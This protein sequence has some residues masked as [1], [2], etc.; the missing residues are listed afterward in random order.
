LLTEEQ[1]QELLDDE[2]DHAEHGRVKRTIDQSAFL[3][4]EMPIHWKFDGHHS[5]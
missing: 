1:V 3:R 2:K 4:W 5:K